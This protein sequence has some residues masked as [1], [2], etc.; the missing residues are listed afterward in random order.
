MDVV[1]KGGL[2]PK[3]T[4]VVNSKPGY[5][6]S[7]LAW[8]KLN[9]SIGDIFRRTFHAF[10]GVVTKVD[11]KESR[12]LVKIPNLERELWANYPPNLEKFFL[13]NQGNLVEFEGK[14]KLDKNEVPYSVKSIDNAKLADESNIRVSEVLPDFLRVKTLPKQ[15]FNV[16]LTDD[17]Q[18]YVAEYEEISFFC[19]AHTRTELKEAI[20]AHIELDWASFAKAPDETFHSSGIGLKEKLRSMFEEK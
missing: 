5:L 6:R 8:L 20:T 12:I 13:S 3:P 10:I 7:L 18:T 16:Y 14:I 19:W 2:A 4:S 17:K 1:S 9:A 15:Y 11:V